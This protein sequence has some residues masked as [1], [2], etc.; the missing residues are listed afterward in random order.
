MQRDIFSAFA[1]LPRIEEIVPIIE[2]E[3][4]IMGWWTSKIGILGH[5]LE[6][7]SAD[8]VK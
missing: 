2:T 7:G 1:A 4:I 6:N 5:E 3:L 8:V